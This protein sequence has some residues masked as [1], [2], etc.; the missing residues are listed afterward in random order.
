MSTPNYTPPSGD[1]APKAMHLR[2]PRQRILVS[3]SYEK[4]MD[5]MD[6]RLKNIEETLKNLSN[7]ASLSRESSAARTPE[8][9]SL[10]EKSFSGLAS[11][12]SQHDDS[13]L[14]NAEHTLKAQTLHVGEF[15]DQIVSGGLQSQ[16]NSSTTG[17]V[18]HLRRL[19][20]TQRRSS[21]SYS[22]RFPLQHPPPKSLHQLPLP[23]KDLVMT[24]LQ[25]AYL[26]QPTLFTYNMAL[27]GIDNFAGLCEAVYSSPETTTHTDLT[28]LHAGLYYLFVEQEIYG[29]VKSQDHD[30]NTIAKD[31]QANFETC[32]SQ[33]PLFLTATVRHVQA[34]LLSAFYAIDSCWPSVA[35]QLNS[36]AAQLC[37]TGRFHRLNDTDDPDTAKTRSTLFWQVSILDQCLSLRLGR[38]TV[39]Q[40][41]EITIPRDLKLAGLD[42][43]EKTSIPRIWMIT[44]P[45]R[46]RV[47]KDLPAALARPPSDL[48]IIAAN[49][50]IEAQQIELEMSHI[51][52]EAFQDLEP[53]GSPVGL[54]NLLIMSSFVQFYVTLTLIYRK[55][56]TPDGSLSQFCDLCLEA[57]RNAITSHQDTVQVLSSA[58]L[59]CRIYVHW[60]LMLTPFAPFF[61]LF[62]HFMETLEERDLQL[63][64]GF[65][66]SLEKLRRA[67]NTAD[68]LYQIC[69]AMCDVAC[70]YKE[71]VSPQG[72][73]EGFSD[74]FEMYLNQF[75]LMPHD[76]APLYDES[77]DRSDWYSGNRSMF[78]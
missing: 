6:D 72:S 61:V 5:T 75:G 14:L 60:T 74:E 32:I 29:T 47:Y 58:A 36:T 12:Q 24:A 17:A 16:L 49:F 41:S 35:W 23:P 8:S 63:I 33:F 42:Q 11:P 25:E 68:K 45:L 48:S 57:A 26:H 20:N 65:T 76:L 69:K 31:C 39:I 77:A 9:L 28:L 62:C 55:V 53:S 51:R 27:A 22:Q 19:L 38:S 64:Q 7:A 56:Q 3:R 10:G 30:H 37:Q 21:H 13:L 73:Y 34:L 44:S 43:L 78:E 1:L 40:E 4:K 67:S 54:N 70:A 46:A 52:Q 59:Y 18:T 2:D 71:D 66:T 50:G 15:L